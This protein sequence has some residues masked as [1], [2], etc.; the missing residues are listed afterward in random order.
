VESRSKVS[1]KGYRDTGQI[2]IIYDADTNTQLSAVSAKTYGK[3]SLR[4]K[5]PSV[6]PQRLKA[7]TEIQV[8]F[9]DV[10]NAPVMA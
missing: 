4:L 1:I 5:N 6:V 10:K 2:V 8:V 9:S 7:T 3:W